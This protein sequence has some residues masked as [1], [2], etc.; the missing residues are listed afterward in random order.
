M[1]SCRDGEGSIVS[2]ARRS[3]W[4][5]VFLAA[6]VLAISPVAAQTDAQGVIERSVQRNTADWNAFPEYECL[7]RDRE[8]NGGSKTFDDLMV[9]GSPYQRLV[10]VNDKPLSSSDQKEQQRKLEETI[11]R[12]RNESPEQ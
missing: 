3:P 11:E 5:Y 8:P 1:L 6:L 2:I 7:E 12:R 4:K 9:A 10:A